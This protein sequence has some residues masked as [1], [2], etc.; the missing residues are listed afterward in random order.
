MR[1]RPQKPAP[2]NASRLLPRLAKLFFQAGDRSVEDDLKGEEVHPFRILTK[3]FRYALEYFRPCYGSGMDSHIQTIS[4]LQR[5]LGELNDCCSSRELC[6]NLLKV[7]NPASRYKKLFAALDRREADLLEQY[8]AYWRKT[9][10]SPA[11]REN[12]LRYVSHPPPARRRA[13]R[14]AAQA[15]SPDS[16]NSTPA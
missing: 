4:G 2:E 5:V 1:L 11:R 3:R 16:A 7:G 12:F 6:R 9:L 10:E 14:R 15:P 13:P 8:R